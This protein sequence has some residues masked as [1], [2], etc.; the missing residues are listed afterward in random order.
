MSMLSGFYKFATIYVL[1][2]NIIQTMKTNQKRKGYT[3]EQMDKLFEKYLQESAA[4]LRVKLRA[5][6]KKSSEIKVK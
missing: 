1:G 6:W 3:I 5:A 4:R 2:I